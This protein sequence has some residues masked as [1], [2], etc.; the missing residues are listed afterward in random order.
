MA[1]HLLIA[2]RATAEEREFVERLRRHPQQG[3]KLLTLFDAT[4]QE[5]AH[6]YAHARA[7]VLPSLAEGFG[8]PLVEARARG[9]LVIASDIQAFKELADQGVSFFPRH[10]EERLAELIA[11]HVSLQKENCPQSQ[12]CVT[13]NQSS[14]ELLRLLEGTA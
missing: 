14:L 13:W 7:L 8:L 10:S 2:G 9:C 6:V 11:D 5:L 1:A 12:L 3:A 4:D